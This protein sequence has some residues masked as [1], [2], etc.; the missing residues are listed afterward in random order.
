MLIQNPKEPTSK[1]A[2]LE[3]YVRSQHALLEAEALAHARAM[4]ESRQLSERA[5]DT[6]SQL[7]RSAHDLRDDTNGVRLSTHDHIRDVTLLENGLIVEH[8]D[9]KREARELALKLGAVEAFTPDELEA[10]IKEDFAVENSIVAAWKSA[11]SDAFFDVAKFCISIG[12][13]CRVLRGSLKV[14]SK[15]SMSNVQKLLTCFSLGCSFCRLMNHSHL[16]RHL[17]EGVFQGQSP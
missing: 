17:H 3:N 2:N 11:V 5:R 16:A 12:T 10:K 15:I 7:R 14:H 9:V 13:T 4:H 1:R 8:V 6:Y